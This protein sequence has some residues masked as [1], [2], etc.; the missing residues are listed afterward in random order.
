MMARVVFSRSAPCSSAK[1][2]T[3]SIEEIPWLPLPELLITVTGAPSI[4][5]SQAELV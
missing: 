2:K 1:V 3:G 5:A 4:R